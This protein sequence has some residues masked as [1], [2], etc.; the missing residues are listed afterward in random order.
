MKHLLQWLMMTYDTGNL[1]HFLDSRL[2]LKTAWGKSILLS[3]SQ[4]SVPLV[5]FLKTTLSSLCGN[6]VSHLFTQVKLQHM[7]EKLLLLLKQAKT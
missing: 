1:V 3:Q 4:C 2:T 7:K 5:V 6:N